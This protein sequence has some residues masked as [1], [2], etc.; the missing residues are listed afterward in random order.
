MSLGG[1]MRQRTW[2][3]IGCL[4]LALG[5]AAAGKTRSGAARDEPAA[6][7]TAKARLEI[8]RGVYEKT[9]V[10]DS[11]PYRGIQTGS[12]GNWKPPEIDDRE[13]ENLY[14]WSRRWMEAERDVKPDGSGPIAA[15]RGH[16]SRMNDLGSGEAIKDVRKKNDMHFNG[17][18]S[19][20]E[21]ASCLGTTPEV[22]EFFRLEADSWLAKA[23]APKSR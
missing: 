3:V 14:Q 6:D 20:A 7:P 11:N 10:R 8:A 1:F 17:E 18:M 16:R 12:M 4:A 21:A 23:T 19:A 5:L 22:L 2:F 15:L 13:A 9:L